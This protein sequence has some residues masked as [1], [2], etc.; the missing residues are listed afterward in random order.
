MKKDLSRR[1][2]EATPVAS[3]HFLFSLTLAAT[4]ALL[5]FRLWYPSPLS[6]LIGVE[7]LF[8]LVVGV[9]VICGPVL[10][11]VIFDKRKPRIELTRDIG[12]IFLI[13][14]WALVYGIHIAASAR[15]VFVAF[16]GDR[17]RV[18][19]A[20]D[21]ETSQIDKAP[22]NLRSLSFTGP[23]PLGVRLSKSGDP[24]FL[25]SL[26][27]ALQGA[28]PSFRPSRWVEF[29]SQKDLLLSELKSIERLKTK[30]E[31][32]RKLIDRALRDAALNDS[33]VGYLPIIAGDHTDWVALVRRKNAEIVTYLPVDGFD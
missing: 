18:V 23:R 5:I 2:R 17:F 10:M 7:G 20:Q 15:P 1:L 26:H 13:Q 9:D 8:L 33:E 12:L 29:D 11:L 14:F 3:I 21:V 27:L 6:E 19:Q 25:Q 22:K 4:S 16:E 28:H 31:P 24:D 32:S 30:H